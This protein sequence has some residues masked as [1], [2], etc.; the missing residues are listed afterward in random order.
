MGRLLITTGVVLVLL[1]TLLTFGPKLPFQLLGQIPFLD[2][3]HQGATA[4][5]YFPL[6]TSIVISVILSVVFAA[7]N[8]R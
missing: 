3:Y 5:F 1:G 2:F 8:R 4:S 6:G 7:R